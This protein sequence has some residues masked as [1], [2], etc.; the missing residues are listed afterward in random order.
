MINIAL[1]RV[2]QF[3]KITKVE[4]AKKM[5]TTKTVI[6]GIESG[7]KPAN[8]RYLERFCEH[9]DVP[10]SSLVFFSESLQSPTLLKIKGRFTLSR[11]MANIMS[12]TKEKNE[13]VS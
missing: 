5:N 4:L 1:K 2:R 12:W 3:H 8:L 13:L 6:S 9:F 10:V 11:K 7:K